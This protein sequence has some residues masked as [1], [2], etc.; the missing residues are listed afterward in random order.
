MTGLV[1]DS[2]NGL[3]SPRGDVDD[4]LALIALLRSGL[5]IAA[6]AGVFGNTAEWRARAN[7]RAL[8]AL[9]GYDG[10]GLAGA[11]GPLRARAPLSEASRFLLGGPS[12]TM[13]QGPGPPRRK[14]DASESGARAR[15]GPAAPARTGPS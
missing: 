15:K 12:A 9:C 11:A 3:G 10:P 1:V 2:D 6:L 13:R 7:H 4:G 8:A 14:R 5:P